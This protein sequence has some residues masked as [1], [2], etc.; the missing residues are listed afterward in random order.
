MV[1]HG[2]SWVGLVRLGGATREHRPRD[3]RAKRDPMRVADAAGS[4]V[5]AAIPLHPVAVQE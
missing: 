3:P 5:P 4:A 1:A 2:S